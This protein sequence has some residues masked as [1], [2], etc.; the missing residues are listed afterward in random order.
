MYRYTTTTDGC[1][2]RRFRSEWP[3][4][5]EF[6]SRVE[7]RFMADYS[8]ANLGAKFAREPGWLALPARGRQGSLRSRKRSGETIRLDRPMTAEGD[9]RL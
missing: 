1:K 4:F 5:R 8:P 6:R 7:R 2:T 3:I 9:F